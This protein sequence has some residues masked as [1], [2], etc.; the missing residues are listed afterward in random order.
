M[1]GRKEVA[2]VL[3]NNFSSFVLMWD[4]VEQMVTNGHERY[5]FL[6]KGQINVLD[7]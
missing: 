4:I 3:K 6:P 7:L 5:W 1:E 2:A